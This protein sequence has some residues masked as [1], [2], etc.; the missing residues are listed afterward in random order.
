V[1]CSNCADDLAGG[2]ALNN[3]LPRRD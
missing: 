1:R 2:D 3:H